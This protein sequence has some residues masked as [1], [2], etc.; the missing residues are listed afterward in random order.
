MV[1]FIRDVRKDLKTPNLPFIIG[2][3]GVGGTEEDPNPKKKAFK[4]AQAAAGERP[5]FKGNVK[6]VKTDVFWDMA[7]E[8]V[9]K[10]GWKENLQEWNTVG[11]D[12]GYHYYGS[13]KTY[14][15]IG[16]AFGK[17]IIELS[18]QKK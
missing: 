6:V 11:S 8:A 5:E 16:A 12:F 14:C 9:Y 10:K 4:D 7:A 17:A 18:Q 2:Q 13:A 3:L 1:N 15:Q